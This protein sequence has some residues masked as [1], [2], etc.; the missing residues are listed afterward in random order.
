MRR[1]LSTAAAIVLAG[2][3]L[4]SPV[5]ASDRSPT[6]AVWNR[7][8]CVVVRVQDLDLIRSQHRDLAADLCFL[9]DERRFRVSLTADCSSP[10]VISKPVPC[11]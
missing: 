7:C 8:D 11:A 10:V 6:V 1:T 2:S 9:P 3:L 5:G 4:S